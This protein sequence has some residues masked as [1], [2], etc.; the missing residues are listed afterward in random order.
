MRCSHCGVCCQETGMLLS[1]EDIDRLE[2]AGYRPDEFFRFD[3]QGYAKLRNSKG[4]CYFYD[5]E[6]RRCRAYRLRPYGC[7]LYPVIC[8]TKDTIILDELC[9]TRNTVTKREM[10][11]KGKDVLNLIE[12]IDKEAVE[13]RSR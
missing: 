3:R 13:R 9:P 8:S 10:E 11:A 5:T 2:K 6:K 4:Y 1:Q 7:R 12:V